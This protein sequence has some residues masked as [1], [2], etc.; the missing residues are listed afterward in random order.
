MLVKK[1]PHRKDRVANVLIRAL[2][3]ILHRKN[4]Y[5]QSQSITVSFIKMT[6]DLRIAN[7]YCRCVAD[8]PEIKPADLIRDLNEK[9]QFI[10]HNLGP[11]LSLKFLPDLVFHYDHRP[12]EESYVQHLLNRVRES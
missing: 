7:V 5:F 8:D 2:T 11:L 10:R 6:N 4:S 1:D 12:E 9:R 3:Q